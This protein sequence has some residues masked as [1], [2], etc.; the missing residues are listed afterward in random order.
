[1]TGMEFDALTEDEIDALPSLPIVV[2][3]CGEFEAF[4][5]LSTHSARAYLFA[6]LFSSRDQG[7]NGRGYPPKEHRRNGSFSSSRRVLPTSSRRSDLPFL[8]SFPQR[9]SSVMTGDGVNDCPALK[10]ADIGF[11][12]GQN[13]SD[14]A[15]GEFSFS[16]PRERT[17]TS[18]ARLPIYRFSFQVRPTSFSPMTTS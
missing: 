12:M 9:C 17:R 15:K 4:L 8:F 2:A 11:A 6:S 1:M 18:S 13:G 14:V 5:S 10:R 16:F 3:R 7:S